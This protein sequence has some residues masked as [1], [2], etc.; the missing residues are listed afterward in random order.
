VG[1]VAV[2]MSS[3]PLLDRWV[4]DVCMY[5][6]M[7]E[8]YDLIYDSKTLN[9]CIYLCVYVCS[10]LPM[11]STYCT[12]NNYSHYEYCN[13]IVTVVLGFRLICPRIPVSLDRLNLTVVGPIT[14]AV[15]L[16]RKGPRNRIVNMFFT[17]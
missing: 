16:A 2:S 15:G 10:I 9:L 1:E 14:I 7:Y 4:V 8:M 6:C 11:G 17:T 3:Q 12:V 13:S 5:E